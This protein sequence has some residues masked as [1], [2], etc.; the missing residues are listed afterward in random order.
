[1]RHKGFTLIELLVVIAIIAIL[2]AIL[3]PVFAQARSK[4]RQAACI[5]HSKQIGLAI[6]MYAEDYDETYPRAQLNIQCP[7]PDICG[8]AI[9][10]VG[11]LYMIQPYSKNNL[12]SQ[13]PEAKKV[14]TS[15]PDGKRL[16]MEGRIGYGLAYPVPG[17][18]GFG[19][20]SRIEAPASHIMVADAV[21]DGPSS[22]ALHN[23]W[24]AYMNHVVSP[25]DPLQGY[26]LN[27]DLSTW[28]QRPHARHTKKVTVIFCDGHVKAL[29]FEG[30][31]PVP[32]S[33]CEGSGGTGCSRLRLLPSDAPHLWEVWK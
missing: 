6:M 17:G 8:T 29:P 3:F 2:A 28:H 5:S 27:A 30:L 12:Y 9:V 11:F 1:M 16:W 32:E 20:M 25:F 24:G 22:I 15:L 19:S 26:G 31:Y 14:D 33:V 7:W 21:P 10:S 13:C 4:A 18:P 23:A